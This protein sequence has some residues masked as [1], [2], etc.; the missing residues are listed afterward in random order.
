VPRWAKG[1]KATEDAEVPKRSSSHIEIARAIVGAAIKRI[2]DKDRKSKVEIAKAAKTTR[3]L[4]KATPELIKA[5]P[6]FH[7]DGYHGEIATKAR[8]E[9][10]AKAR[11][12]SGSTQTHRKTLKNALAS[13]LSLEEIINTGS[14]LPEQKL[15]IKN[16]FVDGADEEEPVKTSRSQSAPAKCPPQRNQ[17]A[18]SS[19]A[20]GPSVVRDVVERPDSDEDS[21]SYGESCR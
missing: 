3:E 10:T 5:R 9:A 1:G 16:T 8:A 6:E 18:A 20:G 2:E 7:K 13:D 15:K 11:S 12:G 21:W 14:A 19:S 4:A 17:A